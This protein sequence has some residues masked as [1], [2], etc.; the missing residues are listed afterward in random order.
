MLATRVSTRRLLDQAVPA[1]IAA[2]GCGISLWLTVVFCRRLDTEMHIAVGIGILWELSKAYY[3]PLGVR[4]ILRSGSRAGGAALCALS[5]VLIAGS[6][7][8]SLAFLTDADASR[9]QDALHASEMHRDATRERDALDRQIDLLT[10]SVAA[11]I[12]QERR[13]RALVTSKDIDALTVQRRAVVA[14]LERMAVPSGA[15]GGQRLRV[16]AHAV[17]AIVLELVTVAALVL[18]R[19]DATPQIASVIASDI[20]ATPENTGSDAT[21]AKY[22]EA[23]KMITTAQ[24]SPTYRA[25]QSALHLSQATAQKYLKAMHEEGVLLRDGRRY[26]WAG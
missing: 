1:I 25:L 3:A 8:A 9:Q 19:R 6:I 14:R 11:D 12:A 26:V 18:M 5:A 22:I 15:F 2:L 13:T 10:Q 20:D 4:I 24:L 7:V 21:D 23:R 17:I 16:V